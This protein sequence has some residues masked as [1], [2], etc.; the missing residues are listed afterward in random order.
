LSAPNS[1]LRDRPRHAV[2]RSVILLVALWPGPLAAPAAAQSSPAAD[3][4]VRANWG[5][6]AI[7]LASRVD[8]TIGGSIE[9]EL[10]L[11]QPFLL[12]RAEAM[13]GRLV[14]VAAIN[15]EGITMPGGELA[16]G[17]A[18]EGFV[19][20]RHPHTYLHEAVISVVPRAVDPAVSISAGRG[21]APFGTDDPM[22]RPFVRYP[23]N[24]HW[25]QVLERWVFIG[26]VRYGP[27]TL[28]AGTFNGNEPGGPDDVG[29][30]DRFADSWS[31]RATIRPLPGIEVQ[32]SRGFVKSPEHREGFGLDQRKWST[33]ARLQRD[34]AG[35]TR[36]YAFV[37]WAETDEY[38]G[39]R[40]TYIFTSV[41]AEAAIDR[42]SWRLGLR[43]ER[44]TRP[45][46]ER[47]LD[48][49]RT[50]RP[51]SDENI[52]GA[53]RWN[54]VTARA[55]RSFSLGGLGL[56]P[57]LEASR[58]SVAEVTGAIFNPVAFYGSTEM[59]SISL[60]LRLRTGMQHER[61]GRYGVALPGGSGRG[62]AA[63]TTPQRG[64]Q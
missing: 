25:S 2:R 3:S 62:H 15:F 37:E 30:L 18:G 59:L 53:T 52:L 54:T 50:T 16:P 46:E 17:N 38:A 60:G 63:H 32:A 1:R 27:A 49:F 47:L 21:F 43:Y 19:D 48:P 11:T 22:V 57:F 64:S 34:L 26:A 12:G 13:R 14:G 44:T 58:S 36:A 51:H 8:P 7:G 56:E 4:R 61:M 41:L 10:Y 24:H 55:G 35:D 20:R 40:K 28:E 39:G 9:S 33:S 45:E 31:V 29:G 42:G 6:H 23:A 5:L